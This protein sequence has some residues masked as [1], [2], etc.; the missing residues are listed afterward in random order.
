M[1]TAATSSSAKLLSHRLPEIFPAGKL[2]LDFLQTLLQKYASTKSGN[3]G[4]KIGAGLGRDAAV[5]DFGDRLLIAKTDPITFVAEDIGYYALHINA[6]DVAC[7]GGEPKWFLA[8]LLLPENNTTPA[9]VEKIFH[10]LSQAC[11]KIGVALCGGHTE[12][13]T[14]IDRPLVAGCLLG[15]APANRSFSP[16]RIEIGDTIILTKGL[17]VEATSI[18]GREHTQALTEIFDAE[19]AQNCKHFLHD[20]GISVLPEAHLAWQ[21]EGVHA[22]HDPTEGGLANAIH[23]LLAERDLGVEI[24]WEN[25]PLLPETKLLCD[26]FR[27]DI[28]GLIA[29]GALLIIGEEKACVKLQTRLQRAKITAAVIGRI[30]PAGEGR[31]LVEGKQRRELPLFRRDEMIKVMVCP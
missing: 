8:T 21:A 10:Q 23:E 3:H 2:P 29:S 15:E 9:L 12:V 13:T 4:L 14:G 7:M 31:W 24:F 27:L 16:E 6:N 20:P 22:L 1:S 5:I 25:I 30:L 11:Q 19:F 26:H 28:L 17:A 18:I